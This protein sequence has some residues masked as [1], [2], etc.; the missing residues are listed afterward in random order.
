MSADESDHFRIIW[1]LYFLCLQLRQIFEGLDIMRNYKG[2][3]TLVE[4][5]HYM[6]PDALHVLN[7]MINNK[8]K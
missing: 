4:E 3:V 6:T 5:D 1:M 8:E 7:M 2:Y